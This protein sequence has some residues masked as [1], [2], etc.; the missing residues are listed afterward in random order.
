[1]GV[2]STVPA[3][4]LKRFT[5]YFGTPT[6]AA[7]KTIQTRIDKE[8]A[9]NKSF[10]L[11]QFVPIDKSADDPGTFAEVDPNDK[12]HKVEVGQGM[13]TAPVSGHDSIAGALSHEMSHFNDIGGT[14]DVQF[15]GHTVYGEGPSK[16]LATKDP[17][18]ALK[19]A[20]NFEYYLESK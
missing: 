20:D 11:S 5:T 15:G 2:A 7:R 6:E 9:L 19:N 18:K 14:D 16:N 17:A 8:L 4:G 1:M 13:R 12:T 3:A 10:K